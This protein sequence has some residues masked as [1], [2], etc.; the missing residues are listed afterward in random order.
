[1]FTSTVSVPT[2]KTPEIQVDRRQDVMGLS[3][4]SAIKTYRNI[5]F[6]GELTMS[7]MADTKHV[8]ILYNVLLL[9]RANPIRPFATGFSLVNDT[10]YVCC[11]NREN[12]FYCQISECFSAAHIKITL[13]L[14]GFLLLSPRVYLGNFDLTEPQ[15]SPYAQESY[16]SNL[17]TFGFTTATTLGQHFRPFG[18]STS[19][20]E[21]PPRATDGVS[22]VTKI[23][24]LRKGS[25]VN[26]RPVEMTLLERYEAFTKN[27]NVFTEFH[28]SLPRPIACK[29]FPR[30]VRQVGNIK[31]VK[32]QC[33]IMTTTGKG[34]R[35][36]RESLPNLGALLTFLA[37]VFRSKSCHRDDFES[38]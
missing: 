26:N 20:R 19:V 5:D 22:T 11:V 1:M 21:D 27:D 18:R 29:A 10:V 2:S 25:L 17:D 6:F 7:S 34:T 33:W 38:S 8:Q 16:L 28:G 36:N 30:I 35:I 4:T 32:R 15:I 12:A 24:W 23:A 14:F 3:A 31:R 13:S 37:D 9:L